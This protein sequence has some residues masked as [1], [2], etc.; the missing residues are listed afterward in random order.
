MA[1][2]KRLT[3]CVRKHDSDVRSPKSFR[4]HLSAEFEME[5]DD[6]GCG[7]LYFEGVLVRCLD[8]FAVESIDR[9]ELNVNLKDKAELLMDIHQEAGFG[10]DFDPCKGTSTT[11]SFEI[12]GRGTVLS[13]QADQLLTSEWT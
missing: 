6:G 8:G 1:S 4:R 2:V 5:G 7:S 10:E 13:I 3:C 9:D 11:E 12:T